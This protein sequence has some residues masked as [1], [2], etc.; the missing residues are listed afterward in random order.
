MQ[1]YIID[2]VNQL[3]DIIKR[4][5]RTASWKKAVDSHEHWETFIWYWDML[6]CQMYSDGERTLYM[7]IFEDG[8]SGIV[9]IH[10]ANR[11]GDLDILKNALKRMGCQDRDINEEGY[12]VLEKVPSTDAGTV[13]E[14]VR[15]WIE[16][17]NG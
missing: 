10:F 8:N 6:A 1:Q 5:H 9:L 13:S 7:D 11:N 15:F 3:K 12:V 4:H 16:K 2:N 14:R 17:I